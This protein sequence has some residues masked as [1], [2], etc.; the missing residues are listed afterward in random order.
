MQVEDSQGVVKESLP[1]WLE[2]SCG[3]QRGHGTAN[4]VPPIQGQTRI[5]RSSEGRAHDNDA[6]IDRID[7]VFATVNHSDVS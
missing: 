5:E 3:I 1:R 4:G 7:D 2:V 6:R